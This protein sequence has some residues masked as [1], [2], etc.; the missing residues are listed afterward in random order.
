MA[1][2]KLETDRLQKVVN[3]LRSKA[4]GKEEAYLL[5]TLESISEILQAIGEESQTLAE[6]STNMEPIPSIAQLVSSI[7]ELL[8]TE[9]DRKAFNKHE[10]NE[11]RELNKLSKSNEFDEVEDEFEDA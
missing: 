3:N 4:V 10:L 5:G 1:S 11:L 2:P 6:E 7:N 8:D 9:R